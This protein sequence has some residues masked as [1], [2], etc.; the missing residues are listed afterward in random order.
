MRQSVDCVLP[1]WACGQSLV[2]RYGS[3]RGF[4]RIWWPFIHVHV[5]VYLHAGVA[6]YPRGDEFTCTWLRILVQ[7]LLCT[8]GECAESLTKA[9]NHTNFIQSLPNPFKK[10]SKNCTC[11]NRTTQ[12]ETPP[13]LERKQFI[14]RYGL[15]RRIIFQFEYFAEFEVEFDFRVW[16]RG[17][18]LLVRKKIEVEI[19]WECPFK[20]N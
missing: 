17:W 9:Q 13:S 10:W 5:L 7:N 15:L 3:E 4:G 11:T 18:S 16:N 12:L 1:L 20:L 14:L 2:W 19:P 6:V 8:M